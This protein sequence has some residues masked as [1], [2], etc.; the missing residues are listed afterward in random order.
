MEITFNFLTPKQE[1][2]IDEIKKSW[3]GLGV[4]PIITK[5]LE[6]MIKSV[7]GNEASLRSS[8]VIATEILRFKNEFPEINLYKKS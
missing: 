8:Q 1:K 4:A 7:K 2:E 3:N 5:Q 6:G